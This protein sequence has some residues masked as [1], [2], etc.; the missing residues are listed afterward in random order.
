M[1]AFQA[2]LLGLL[3]GNGGSSGSLRAQDAVQWWVGFQNLEDPLQLS[4]FYA[5]VP[6][7]Q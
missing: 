2:V 3:Q 7:H 4:K 6:T 5:Q 1:Q